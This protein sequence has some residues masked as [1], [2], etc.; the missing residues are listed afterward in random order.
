MS[1]ESRWPAIYFGVFL[2]LFVMLINFYMYDVCNS[3]NDQISFNKHSIQVDAC[4]GIIHLRNSI[5]AFILDMR[6]PRD[7]PSIIGRARESGLIS[8]IETTQN[9]CDRCVVNTKLPCWTPGVSFGPNGEG[10]SHEV[11]CEC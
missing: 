7:G 8:W 2:L 6:E 5:H 1:K 11:P 3:D 9:N 10:P 4:Q